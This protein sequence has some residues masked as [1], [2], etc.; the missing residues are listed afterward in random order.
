M[1]NISQDPRCRDIPLNETLV[2]L[3]V[4]RIAKEDLY[5]YPLHHPYNT[6]RWFLSNQTTIGSFLWICTELS[7]APKAFFHIKHNYY[8]RTIGEEIYYQITYISPA[9]KQHYTK[10][11]KHLMC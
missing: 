8:K 3:H 4:L 6:V 1:Y 9:T 7:I 10:Q 11:L 2:W 5:S